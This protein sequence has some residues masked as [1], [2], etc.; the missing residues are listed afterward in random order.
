M[1]S[2]RTNKREF[3]NLRLIVGFQCGNDGAAHLR[4]KMQVFEKGAP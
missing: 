1:T 3:D 2:D 4:P